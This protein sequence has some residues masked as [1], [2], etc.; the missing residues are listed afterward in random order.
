MAGAGRWGVAV[1]VSLVVAVLHALVADGTPSVTFTGAA[2][3]V[4]AWYGG[5]GPGLLAS[6]L[7][8]TL[9]WLGLGVG[10]GTATLVL[11][12]GVL[13]SCLVGAL[14]E[15]A[16]RAPGVRG[17][18]VPAAASAPATPVPAAVTPATPAAAPARPPSPISGEFLGVLS[19][20]LRNPLGALRNAL[21]V[22]ATGQRHEEALELST[23]QV[24]R[25]VTLVDGLLDV[26]R[27]ARGA[28]GLE[29][30]VLDL[31]DEIAAAAE[32]ARPALAA[33]GKA[34]HVTRP[35]EPLRLSADRKRLRQV[36]ESLVDNA[37]QHTAAGGNVWLEAHRDG[38]DAVIVV[39][40]DGAGMAS[41]VLDEVFDAFRPHHGE[42]HRR[43]GGLGVGLAVV[44]A[45]AQLH[46]GDA[47]VQSG[48][49]GQGTEVTVRL[50][51]LPPEPGE[52]DSTPAGR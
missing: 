40:D 3:V 44:R 5:I 20:E 49:P 14:F 32:A 25:L 2:V 37:T 18:G 38:R 11:A 45:V 15:Q 23:R 17:P 47:A 52:V 42:P 8:A 39:R 31:G 19:H 27:I 41:E 29:P 35:A 36:V 28:L 50:P 9:A 7:V 13:A 4:S 16:G 22:M 48:V 43:R 34:L 46:G 6:A 24:D 30:V 26:S 21:R 12:E 33:H 51:A 1:L 10:F